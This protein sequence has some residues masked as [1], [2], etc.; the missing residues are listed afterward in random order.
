MSVVLLT[1][2][3]MDTILEKVPFIQKDK[4][5]VQQEENNVDE[6]A[7]SNEEIADNTN[8][9]KEENNTSTENETEENKLTL[10]SIYFNEIVQVDNKNIIQNP[11]NIMVLVNKIFAL[12]SE[13]ESEEL[14]IPNVSFLYGSPEKYEKSLLRKEAADALEKMFADASKSGIELFAVSGYR[15]FHRQQDVFDAQVN[16]VGY[17]EATKVVANPGN[18][19][20]Q[21]GLAMDISNSTSGLTEAFGETVEGKWLMENA[22]RFGFILR[23]PKGME[24]ITGYDYEPWHY[25]YI[26]IKAATEIYEHGLTLEEYFNIVE[27]I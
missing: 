8:T 9:N 10:E 6:Q 11:A 17:E 15:S 27:K 26:G 14:V 25:R 2:C 1:G 20:H 3:N 4:E 13:Y 22:H 19:E 18:S 24:T 16:Q 12:P 23:Y 7:N 21:T 5:N